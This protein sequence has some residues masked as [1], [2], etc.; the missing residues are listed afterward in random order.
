ME[1]VD[2]QAGATYAAPQDLLAVKKM[3]KTAAL[4]ILSAI[5]SG[6]CTEQ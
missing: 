5:V 2:N 3:N 4:V 1:S 6:R